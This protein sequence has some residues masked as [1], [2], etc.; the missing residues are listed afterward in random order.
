MSQ[1]IDRSWSYVQMALENEYRGGVRF[2]VSLA[3]S[4]VESHA[5]YRPAFSG[6]MQ[7]LTDEY[8]VDSFGVLGAT[9]THV[10]LRPGMPVTNWISG[11]SKSMDRLPTRGNLFLG[12]VLQAHYPSL[13]LDSV[14]QRTLAEMLRRGWTTVFSDGSLRVRRRRVDT[15][16]LITHLWDVTS[17]RNSQSCLTQPPSLWMRAAAQDDTSEPTTPDLE[18]SA[19]LLGYYRSNVTRTF[20]SMT[21]AVMRYRLD[22]S[23]SQ[24]SRAMGVRC[25]EGH[26]TSFADTCS[27]VVRRGTRGGFDGRSLTPWFSKRGAVFTYEDRSSVTAKMKGCLHVFRSLG[28]PRFGWAL[29]DIEQELLHAEECDLEPVRPA[30]HGRIRTVRAILDAQGR[31]ARRRRRRR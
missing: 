21:M 23:H 19:H 4:Y 7:R 17:L 27:S 11:M 31:T 5:E 29:F 15:L 9:V 2:G 16:V 14:R 18:T 28:E 22:E 24:S 12:I 20:L 25:V 8:T 30:A 3:P 26:P 10:G 1:T 13:R 6:M